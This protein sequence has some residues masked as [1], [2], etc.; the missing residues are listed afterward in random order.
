MAGTG[1][2]L[3]IVGF[4]GS[5]HSQ[6]AL[7][8]AVDEAQRRNGQAPPDYRL[9]QAGDGVVSGCPGNSGG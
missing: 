3:I 2:F 8:W 5:E 6:A 4:D 1:S 9:E 7:T